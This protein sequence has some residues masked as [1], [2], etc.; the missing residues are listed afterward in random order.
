VLATVQ[1]EP[2]RHEGAVEG[3]FR[4]QA[5]KEIHHLQHHEEYFRER[6]RAKQR[7]NPRVAQIGQQ[8]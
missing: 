7:R 1:L 6:P 5:A 4:Q 8:P 3:G 2:D